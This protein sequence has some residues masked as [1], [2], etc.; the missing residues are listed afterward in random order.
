MHYKKGGFIWPRPAEGHTGYVLA[1][2]PHTGV[3]NQRWHLYALNKTRRTS[4]AFAEHGEEIK[5]MFDALRNANKSWIKEGE[6]ELQIPEP[7]EH[8]TRIVLIPWEK[9]EQD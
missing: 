4:E 8:N 5:R 9:T 3:H 6:A 1:Y 7:V 2:N